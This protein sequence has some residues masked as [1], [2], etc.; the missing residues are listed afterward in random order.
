MPGTSLISLTSTIMAFR[1]CRYS[2][3]EYGFGVDVADNANVAAFE[4]GNRRYTCGQ[5]KLVLTI[6]SQ[7]SALEHR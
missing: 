4:R 3:R 6:H 1:H 2:G 5:K 7:L